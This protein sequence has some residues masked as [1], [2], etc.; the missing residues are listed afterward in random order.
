MADTEHEIRADRL[1]KLESL[2]AAGVEPYPARFDG[3][4]PI[5][6][7]RGRFGHLGPG[8][9][10]G[11]VARVAGRI[12][13]RRGQGK[14]T[15]LDLA[16]RSGQIQLHATEDV[17]GE[18]Y[19]AVRDCDLGDVVGVAGEVFASRRGELSIRVRE[20]RLLAKCLRPLPDKWHGLAD[21]EQRLRQRYL[22]LLVNERSR[23]T[24]LLRSRVVTAI[25]R[26]LD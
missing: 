17:L 18:A 19:A 4:E 15:F 14:A 6:D 9:E 8:E 24:A 10:S 25:R 21:V 20:W 3:R 23:E 22:D 16:D 12:G 7:V 13:A 5:A 1:A 2:R 11:E 26:V